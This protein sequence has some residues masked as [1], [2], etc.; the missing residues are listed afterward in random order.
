M[1]VARGAEALEAAAG[2]LRADAPAGTQVQA[3][4]TDITTEEGRAKVFAFRKDYDIVVTNAGAIG[5]PE[6]VDR[7]L[8]RAGRD[9]DDAA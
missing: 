2:K 3:I 1:I 9:I 5:Q 4:A 7:R 8:D 6:D